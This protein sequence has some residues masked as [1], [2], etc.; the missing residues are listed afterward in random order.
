MFDSLK[1]GR[2]K[3]NLNE[4]NKKNGADHKSR[5]DFLVNSNVSTAFVAV[6]FNVSAKYKITY[7]FDFR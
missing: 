1:N 4:D 7:M 5:A 6:H 2:C 3:A